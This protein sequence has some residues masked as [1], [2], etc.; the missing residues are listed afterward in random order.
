[1][2]SPLRST[3]RFGPAPFESETPAARVLG[4]ETR[5]DVSETSEGNRGRGPEIVRGDERRTEELPGGD[6]HVG[7][8]RRRP[9]C[10]R[11]L[12]AGRT[13]RQRRADGGGAVAGKHR[14]RTRFEVAGEH[15]ESGV[16]VGVP[17]PRGRRASAPNCPVTGRR[18]APADGRASNPGGPRHPRGRPCAPRSRRGRH[19][20][21]GDSPLRRARSAATPRRTRRR[22]RR[23]GMLAAAGAVP[24]V[25]TVSS[26]DTCPKLRGKTL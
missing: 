2:N 12:Q 25:E 22:R 24:R 15:R 4:P 3:G 17:S 19:E 20:R 6:N 1:M 8:A 11:A 10:R 5:Q 14:P 13:H 26:A 16:R 23:R 9:R 18:R 7:E 21:S